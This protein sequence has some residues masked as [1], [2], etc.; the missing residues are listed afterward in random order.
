[1]APTPTRTGTRSTLLAGASGLI[2]RALLP[3]LLQSTRYTHV[4]VL[5]RRSVPDLPAHDKQQIHLVDFAQLPV[6][7][8]V[9]DVFVALGTTIKAA[10]SQDAFRRIDFDAVVATARAALAAGARRL[11]VVSAL[12]A[13]PASRTFYN[14][15]KGEMQQAVTAL[16]YESVII[17]QPSL[18][19]G[20]RAR[21]GQPARRGEEWAIR[22]LHPALR[23]VPRS[24]RPIQADSVAQAM[25]RAALSAAPGV[26]VLSSGQMQAAP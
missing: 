8:G 5:L 18:L 6:L 4:H 20:D 2:G 12:G 1:M 16:G 7:P 25:L 11:L 13:D 23:W 24:V 3:L 19:L 21:L 14:R 10:G 22:L 26:T 9:D 15:V 17:A